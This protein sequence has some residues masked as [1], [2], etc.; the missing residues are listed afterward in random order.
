MPFGVGIVFALMYA[1]FNGYLLSITYLGA[2][3][4]SSLSGV[5]IVEGLNV[6]LVLALLQYIISKKQFKLKKW[7]VFIFAILSQVVYIIGN[8]GDT[9]SNLALFIS[10]KMTKYFL[11]KYES[12]LNV[13]NN[14]TN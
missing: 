7:Q 12:I 8:I 5:G 6:S 4:L 3:A 2:Y 10:R 13:Q 1:K 9:K 14:L 11:K